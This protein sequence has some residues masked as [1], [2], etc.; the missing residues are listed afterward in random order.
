MYDETLIE[1]KNLQNDSC[2]VLYI[3]KLQANFC[4]TF[5]D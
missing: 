5:Q 3:M 4:F 1:N 2:S